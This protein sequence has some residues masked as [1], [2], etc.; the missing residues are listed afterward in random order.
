M[1]PPRYRILTSALAASILLGSTLAAAPAIAAPSATCAEPQ[2]AKVARKAVQATM[3]TESVAFTK[4][5][6]L[7]R[8]SLPAKQRAQAAV[9]ADAT[10]TASDRGIAA[11]D[12]TLVRQLI[13]AASATSKPLSVDRAKLAQCGVSAMKRL[14]KHADVREA[15]FGLDVL[16]ALRN[17]ERALVKWDSV[18]RDRFKGT[19]AAQYATWRTKVKDEQASAAALTK[20]IAATKKQLR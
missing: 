19:D 14:A 12:V 1:Y 7:A 13:T 15:R 9:L 10:S 5:L 6:K 18:T 3:K 4:T 17:H 16:T 2:A 11:A 20:Q 8:T